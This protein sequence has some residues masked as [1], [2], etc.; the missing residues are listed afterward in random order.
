MTN[1]G[2]YETR[3]P[4]KRAL[5][6]RFLRRTTEAVERTGATTI[7]DVGTG[8]GLFWSENSAQ[9]TVVGVDVRHDALQEARTRGL[10]IPAMG[11]AYRLPFPD[12]SFDL[13]VAIEILEHLDR[14]SV[15]VDEIGRVTK[16][17]AVITVPW[18]PWFSLGVLFGSG[19]HWRRLGREPE[20]V[21]AFG[22]S[23]LGDALGTRFGDVRIITCAPWIIAE[24]STPRR[25]GSER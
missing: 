18:E 15:A 3:N 11:S 8:E 12:D 5:L 21:N 20:H 14:P 4:L 1:K 23:E 16:S 9:R 22:P 19:Q 10:V 17:N 25:G 2:K 24:C 7:L 6:N 13:V